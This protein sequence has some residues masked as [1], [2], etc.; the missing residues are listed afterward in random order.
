MTRSL[1]LNFRKHLSM[2]V[3]DDNKELMRK[4]TMPMARAHQKGYFESNVCK[5]L[6]SV[7]VI[8]HQ[9]L[10]AGGQ[11]DDEKGSINAC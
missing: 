1:D 11:N 7:M 9:E 2:S 10:A 5:R 8:G 3:D 6:G 4:C